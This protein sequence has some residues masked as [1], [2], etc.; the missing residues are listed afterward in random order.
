MRSLKG[1]AKISG[2]SALLIASVPSLA[3]VIEYGDEDVLGTGTYTPPIPKRVPP[4]RGWQAVLGHLRQRP[5]GIAFRSR[6]R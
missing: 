6:R 4:L 3:A 1:I 5:L 2:L